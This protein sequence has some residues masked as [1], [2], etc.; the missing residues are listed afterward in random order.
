MKILFLGVG[1]GEFYPAMLCNCSLCTKYRNEGKILGFSSIL[2]DNQF[3]FDVPP[4][5]NLN[6][7]GFKV[8]AKFPFYIFVT[9][10]H[11]D[12]FDP[13]EILSPRENIKNEVFIHVNKTVSKLLEH[14]K[15]FNR[16]F[17]LS[18]PSFKNIFIKPIK[19][20]KK[21]SV[22]NRTFIIPVLA[23][24]DKT[25]NEESMNY[26]IKIK[27]KTVLYA[28][29]TGWYDNDD[30]WKEILK[31]QYNVLILEFSFTPVDG[32][33]LDYE[34][35]MKLIKCLR[36]NK[37]INSSTQIIATHLHLHRLDPEQIKLLEQAGVKVAFRGMEYVC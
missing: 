7:A 34:H 3:L 11:Q 36:K 14:Y 35:F 22:D 4:G 25:Y 8:R 2:I 18:C 28:S 37:C 31:H 16:F 21:I 24:H 19:A 17:D 26:I 20:F 6:L 13:A 23:N 12:H 10:S 5:T 27:N 30:T 9:H 33:H 32:M 1:A 15:K 29:D